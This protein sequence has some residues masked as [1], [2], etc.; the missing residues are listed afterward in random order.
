MKR[1]FLCFPL[2]ALAFVMVNCSG[3]SSMVDPTMPNISGSWEFIAM[4]TVNPGYSTG[5]EVALQEGQVFANGGY[6]ENGQISAAGPQINFIGF[7]PAVG[8]NSPP[9]IVFGG[10]C[11]PASTNPGNSL[12]GSISGLGGTLNFT[13]TENG[14]VFNVTALLDASS[15]FI[16][17]GT[18][19]EQAASAGQSNGVCNGSTDATVIDTGTITGKIVPK[20]TGT[21]T[22]QMCQPL[23]T[24][25]ANPQDA[26]TATLSGSTTLTLNLLLS[27]ADNAS[28]TLTGPVT[29][30]EFSVQG[31][32]Q[33]QS[34]SYT[35]YYEQTDSAA[36][37]QP[38]LYLV[39]A[40]N[41]GQPT[42]AGTLTVPQ[43]Q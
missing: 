32:Y 21:Y 26:A 29:G 40:T 41:S 30:N 15:Q 24:L 1:I 22:G 2:L 18:Y 23:D 39:N 34:V 9:N 7:T 17:S 36:D 16:D 28:L 20:L 4:S 11:S 6:Q 14:N 5:I 27:G 25:C 38:A 42:Y 13:Y 35:G 12:A 3:K 37:N 43:T 10:N 33:G 8:L 19:T 31:T